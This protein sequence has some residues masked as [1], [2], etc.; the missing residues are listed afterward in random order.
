MKRRGTRNSG[1]RGHL[2]TEQHNPNTR[3]L[4]VLPIG[5]AFDVMNAEDST[6][7]AAVAHAKGPIVR[8]IRRVSEAWRCG[9]RLI[10]VGAGTSGRLG[11]LDAAE[12]P[13]TFRSS[14]QMVRGVVAGGKKALWR[15]VEGA[16]DDPAAARAAIRE[17][18]VCVKDVVLGIASGGTTPYVH[19]A[20][21]EA[22]QR[23]A[24]TAFLACVPKSQVEVAC[25]I[26]IRVLVA[27]EVL[28]GSTR[29]KAGTATK[30]VLNMI[31]TLGMVRLGKTYGN[32]M[33]DLNSH[34]CR[35]LVDRATRVVSDATG[36]PGPEA[37][38]L[39][40]AARGR[41]KTAIVMHLL[42]ISRAE[43]EAL[44]ARNSGHVGEALGRR[45]RREIRE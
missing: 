14:P 30:L 2:L 16:E 3:D 20:L 34:A 41:A 43:A 40:R 32:L 25:D 18:D 1:G 13:P 24:T 12:C 10:Y 7:P 22:K 15:S 6:V 27:A 44:L 35:K 37:A 26:D 11:V 36:L 21:G 39:L 31:T 9:G 28:S 29:L 33:V 19:A 5:D 38:R 4:D 23:G 8:M 42:T 17:L 45:R